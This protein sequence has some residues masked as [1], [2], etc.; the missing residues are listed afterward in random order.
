MKVNP[1]LSIIRQC[2]HWNRSLPLSSAELK[3][4]MTCIM[5]SLGFEGSS[6]T[7]KLVG[8]SGIAELNESYLGCIGP[9]NVLSFPAS[10]EGEDEDGYLGEIA[11][12]VNTLEREI[13]LYGQDSCEHLV[14][15]LSHATLHLA[16]FDHGEEMDALTEVA[17]SSCSCR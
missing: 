15:L 14:R 16:G 2:L 8:D 10:D 7:L 17:I 9:T 3:C 4:V 13:Q 1:G 5:A 11:L 6:L 12:S